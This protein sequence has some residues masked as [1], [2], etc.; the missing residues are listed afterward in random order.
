MRHA[1]PHVVKRDVQAIGPSAAELARSRDL[2]PGLFF[3]H[4]A[5]HIHRRRNRLIDLRDGR[6]DVLDNPSLD[7]ASGDFDCDLHH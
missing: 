1:D 6:V 3:D 5:H 4:R 7:V 2:L